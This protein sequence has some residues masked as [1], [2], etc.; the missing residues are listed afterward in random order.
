MAFKK[1]E[2][3][4]LLVKTNRRCCICGKQHSVTVHH[5]TSKKEGGSDN[6]ENGI[7]LCPNCH[8]EVHASGATGRVTRKYTPEELKGH[9]RIQRISGAIC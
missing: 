6:I 4:E 9:L 7:P 8:D 2:A 5:I 3:S 1:K